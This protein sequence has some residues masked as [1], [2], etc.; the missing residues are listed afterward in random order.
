MKFV[1]N[2]AHLKFNL[3][4]DR[5]WLLSSALHF[6]R[7][8]WDVLC[9]ADPVFRYVSESDF[10]GFLELLLQAKDDV[11]MVKWQKYITCWP[12]AKLLRQ[13]SMPE[14]PEGF[15]AALGGSTLHFPLGG[16]ARKHLRNLLASRPG[17]VRSCRVMWAILQGVKRGTVEVPEDFISTTMA[18]HQLSMTQVLPE[19]SDDDSERFRLK[20]REIWRSSQTVRG[21]DGRRYTAWGVN[22]RMRHFADLPPDAGYNACHESTRAQ[23]GRCGWV[24]DTVI[25]EVYDLLGLE[26]EG[27]LWRMTEVRPGQVVEERLHRGFLPT[28][29]RRLATKAALKQLKQLGG[30]CRAAVAGILEPLK[31]RL[32]T[33]GPGVVYWAASSFQRAM[34][35]RLQDWSCFRLTGRPLCASDLVDVDR[36]TRRLGLGFHKWVSGDYSAATDGLSQAINRLCLEEAIMAGGLSEGEAEVA[37]AVLGNHVIEYP[38]EFWPKLPLGGVINQTNGQLMGS[39]LSFPVLCAINVAAYWIALEEHTGRSIALESLPVLVNGDDI[40]F[41][42]D[43]SFYAVWQKWTRTAGFTLSAGKNYISEHFATIN[44]EGFVMRP[45][46]EPIKVDFLNT[47][48]LY[49]GE[50]SREVEHDWRESGK[51]IKVGLRPENREM[52]FTAKVNRVIAE[53]CDPQ[54][55]LLR[56]HEFYR[57]DIRFHTHRGEINMHAAPE[58]GGLGIILPKGSSTRFTPWQQKVAGYL[59]SRWKSL[60]FGTKLPGEEELWDLNAPMGVEGRCTYQCKTRPLLSPQHPVL[61]GRVVVRAKMEPCRAGEVQWSLPPS[62][63]KNYQAPRSSDRGEWKIRQLSSSDLE[64]CRA[65]EGER[66]SSPLEWHD[67]LRVQLPPGESLYR[68]DSQSAYVYSGGPNGEVT[69]FRTKPILLG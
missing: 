39:V 20:F 29:T 44:S 57:Q 16:R 53:S 6:V 60:D 26:V 2:S 31:C 49:A 11:S 67:E 28:V 65:Y 15:E 10:N 22:S 61:P 3:A 38:E 9:D 40:C 33:K 64:R 63:L 66:V 1:E 48:L 47:G 7:A 25:A 24:R 19:L 50:A 52:P 18:K 58:L 5:L 30:V 13:E 37:R 4:L 56:V 32:I 36:R 27:H 35:E 14:V 34:W 8:T 43:D 41:K 59:R 17:E 55:T 54:R 51:R 69:Y 45:G 62:G 46:R 42:A 12:M 23:G 68:T 21:A